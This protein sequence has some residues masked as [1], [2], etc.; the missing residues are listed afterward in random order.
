M[1]WNDQV[2]VVDKINNK[3][4]GIVVSGDDHNFAPFDPGDQGSGGEASLLL[5]FPVEL[6]DMGLESQPEGAQVFL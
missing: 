5:Q 2:L 1:A 6:E 3:L 4:A